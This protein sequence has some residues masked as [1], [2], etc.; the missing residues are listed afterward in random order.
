MDIE[1]INP[2]DTNDI[3]LQAINEASV[4]IQ[5]YAH[6]QNLPE[7]L[8]TIVQQATRL[9]RASGGGFY[10]TEPE[11][12]LVRCVVSYQTPKDYRGTTLRYGEGLAGRVA[13]TG[14][15]FIIQDYRK[16]AGR[17]EAFESEQPFRAVVSAPVFWQGQVTGVLHVLD[18]TEERTFTNYDLEVLNLFAHQAAIAIEN[19]RLFQAERRRIAE[20][21]AIRQASLGLVSSLNLNQVLESI[22][23]SAM[24]LVPE[25]LISQ[26]FLYTSKDGGE[27]VFG[28]SLASNGVIGQPL[29]KPRPHGLTYTVA[30]SGEI[31]VVPD[32]RTHPLFEDA[33]KEWAG[34]AIGIPLK[35]G[36]RVV[37]VM[38]I[39]FVEPRQVKDETLD[40][41]SLLADH[42]AMAIENARL[43]EQA[44]A[45]RRHLRL[46]FDISREIST[47]LDPEE[48]LKR[49]THL[50]CN[51]LNGLSGAGY[52]YLPDED[53]LRLCALYGLP[54]EAIEDLDRE[55]DMR[56]GKGLAGWVAEHWQPLYLADVTQDER[57]IQAPGVDDNARS[58]ISSPILFGDQ[59]LG[60]VTV[61]HRQPASFNEEQLVL[62]QAICQS[63]AP[64]LS[65][66]RAY[67]EVQRRL[68][69]ITLIQSLTHVFSQQLEVQDLLDEVVKQL[70]QRLGYRQILIYLFEKDQLTLKASHEKITGLKVF[71]PD[72]GILDLVA[73]TGQLA[74]VPPAS[75]STDK[76]KT[77]EA[78]AIEIDVPIYI[79]K[80]VVGVISVRGDALT[81]LTIQDS[82]LLQVLAGQISVALENATLYE[83]VRK[84][85]RDLETIVAQ[86]TAELAEL[87]S[88]S[89]EIGY[90]LSFQ[91]L[92]RRLVRHLRRAIGCSLTAVYLITEER[93]Y[94]II[95]TQRPFE[96]SIEEQI[97]AFCKK[98][99]AEVEVISDER[100]SFELILSEDYHRDAPPLINLS[101][102][103][104]SP[105]MAGQ[106]IVGVL[107]AADDGATA[108]GAEQARLLT[109][110]AN[111]ASS[112]VTRLYNILTE[113]QQQLE[114]LV[115]HLPVGVLLLDEEFRILVANPL[116]REILQAMN[117]Q[118]LPPDHRLT[119]LGAY[120]LQRLTERGDLLSP[121]EI[122]VDEKERRYYSAQIR[123]VGDRSA[124]VHN[125]W[126]LMVSDITQE[127][128]NLARLHSQDR[129]ASVGQLAAGIAHDFNNIMATILVYTDLLMFDNSI[130]P[131]GKDKLR[132]IQAQIQRASSLIRQ[133]LDF[134]R[135]SVIEH[136]TLDLLPMLKEFDKMLVRVLPETIHLEL[137]YQPGAYWVNGDPARLQ[138]VFMN[139]ALN[140]RDAMPQGGTLRFE[141]SIVSKLPSR[142]QPTPDATPK[143]WICITVSDSGCGMSPEVLEHIFE[144]FYTTKPAGRG[145]GLGLPQVYG[146]VTQ[147]G[148]AIEV[149]SQNGQG[150]TFRIYLPA[151]EVEIQ[152]ER[153]TPS[154]PLFDGRG[155]TVLVVEDDPATRLALS[156]LLEAVQCTVISASNGA[157]ALQEFI[158]ADQRIDLV[159][160]D[161]VM[162]EMGGIGL[163]HAIREMNPLVKVL[164][165]TGHPLDETNQELLEQGGVVWLQ[166]PFSISEFN[167]A[168]S[169][170]FNIP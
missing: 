75:P 168:L 141:L 102:I 118:P 63:L 25:A 27:L 116:G 145:T 139:L 123:P 113:Q 132:V 64:A 35:I 154:P 106:Q 42:A 166:K 62:L 86:R 19:A 121:I 22:L 21:E 44:A 18:Y 157:E 131:E 159:I 115:E 135:K 167:Q 89:Q 88:L 111:Q 149:N 41:L 72:E 13:Q 98:D 7:L 48:I 58:A 85:T 130:S 69:E 114:R 57:W 77:A 84:Q 170:I 67:Q 34:S 11:K 45:E 117:N 10:L 94:F 52:I 137:A 165:I 14:E 104:Q 17:A 76:R 146:I 103:R 38:D 101:A 109:T 138:Q 59:L 156:T 122:V 87:Y 8:E 91:D 90:L 29:G 68:A 30:R 143:A 99:L 56:P 80:T 31:I 66:A 147:H 133:I 125:P 169:K 79:G 128:E 43:F 60:V 40:A 65:N 28:T 1:P 96:S 4:L 20:L 112:A 110:F 163:Y 127:K 47:S 164:L 16:W 126:V 152:S 105:I 134:S 46:L 100:E 51:A 142:A 78:T 5:Q 50:T 92:L 32:M 150:T 148:G 15:P 12:Q 54:A 144:P 81:P 6:A 140:A 39:L 61:L 120:E 70:S 3:T 161:I 83:R 2:K 119:R 108:L 151:V 155:S 74:F 26:V 97:R 158:Q 162:P 24:S 73:H 55:L 33:P 82:N 107:L 95:E 136:V 71:S 53:R 49:A 153:Q 23:R 124:S 129:L 37:G 93:N 36:E 160:S 9:L